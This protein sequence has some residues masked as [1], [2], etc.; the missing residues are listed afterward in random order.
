MLPFIAAAQPG[1][2][3]LAVGRIGFSLYI[4]LHETPTWAQLCG[5]AFI[6]VGTALASVDGWGSHIVGSSSTWFKD[7]RSH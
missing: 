3:H 4:V 2:F 6:L 5:S 1:I 7:Q